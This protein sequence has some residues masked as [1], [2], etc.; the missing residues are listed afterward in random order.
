MRKDLM[1]REISVKLSLDIINLL[2]RGKPMT[3]RQIGDLLEVSESNISY[4]KSGRHGFTV[5]RLLQLE[6]LLRKPLPVLFIEAMKTSV[7][8]KMRPA[9]AALRKMLD[10]QDD[11]IKD[12]LGM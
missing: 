7:S 3:N 2:T 6:K 12:L 8:K 11:S 10:E 1:S 9:Y 5:G 4:I